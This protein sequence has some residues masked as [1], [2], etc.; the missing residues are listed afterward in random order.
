MAGFP[1]LRAATIH[2]ACDLRR[3]KHCHKGLVPVLLRP[4]GS[5]YI[6]ADAHRVPT[7]V[8]LAKDCCIMSGIGK[9]WRLFF[10]VPNIASFRPHASVESGSCDI[11]EY[12][13]IIIASQRPR[14]FFLD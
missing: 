13:L 6:L 5:A 4:Q 10:F 9:C 3:V 2:R 8:V 1:R 12:S 11:A 7:L 14:F